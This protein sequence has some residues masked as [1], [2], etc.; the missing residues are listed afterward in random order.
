MN[1]YRESLWRHPIRRLKR[2][3]HI[4]YK[5]NKKH[6]V[7]DILITLGI[8]FLIGLNIFWLF[9]GFHYLIDKTIVEIALEPEQVGIGQDATFVIKYKNENKFDLVEFNLALHLPKNFELKSVNRKNYDLEHNVLN[10]GRLKAGVQG[11]LK[12]SGKIWGNINEK[13]RLSLSI[14]YYKTDRQGKK[15]WGMFQKPFVFDYQ[16]KKTKLAFSADLPVK[17][18]VGQVWKTKL[19]LVNEFSQ[20]LNKIIVRPMVN[21]NFQIIDSDKIFANQQWVFPQ[22][23]PQEKVEIA[24]QILLSGTNSVMPIIKVFGEI[25]GN[26]W[27]LAQISKNIILFDP[28]FYTNLEYKQKFVQPGDKVDLVIYYANEGSF[29]LENVELEL[30]FL[31]VYW[32]I[33]K[34]Q[35][36]VGKI[37]DENKIL[38]SADDISRLALVQPGEKNKIFLTVPLK[39]YLPKIMP[40]LTVRLNSKY[41]VDGLA[42]KMLGTKKILKLSSNLRVKASARYFTDFGEQ[43]GRG[44]LPP[45]VGEETKYWIFVHIFNDITAV[46]DVKVTLKLPKNVYWLNKFNVTVGDA[47]TFDKSTRTVSWKISKVPV[48]PNNFGFMFN[49]GLIPTV[50]QKGT[51]AVLVENITISGVDIFSNQEITEIIPAITTQLKEDKIGQLKG[52]KVY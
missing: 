51:Y 42:V 21:E 38:I 40:Q 18:V 6:L 2:R 35:L 48:S 45:H 13:Q 9:G 52:G 41:K 15:M 10:I 25:N 24:P 33:Q 47:L 19:T 27:Q 39:N 16:L 29:S 4:R 30:E 11:C 32:D 46:K 7:M 22:L 37:I 50:S 12:I 43:L 3:W 23:L 20:T 26:T 34:A 36:T 49:V 14:N 1:Y 8:I 28:H 31:S 5:F 17:A 44:P